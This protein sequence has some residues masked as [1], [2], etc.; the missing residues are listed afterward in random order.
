[1]VEGGGS[2]ALIWGSGKRTRTDRKDGFCRDEPMPL[3]HRTGRLCGFRPTRASQCGP[4]CTGL[5]RKGA[6]N[7]VLVYCAGERRLIG[8][9][10]N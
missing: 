9:A 7:G 4:A 5:G 6:R 2:E 1:M 10:Y 3:R 8:D